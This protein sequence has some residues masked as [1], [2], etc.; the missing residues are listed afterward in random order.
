MRVDGVAV[1]T[2]AWRSVSVRAP[3]DHRVSLAATSPRHRSERISA[4]ADPFGIAIVNSGEFSA[5]TGVRKRPPSGPGLSCCSRIAIVYNT[6]MA[7]RAVSLTL[8]EGNLLWLRG[9]GYGKANLSA[10]VDN[11]VTEARA[12]KLGNAAD[13]RS[14]AGTID[15]ATDDPLLER[16]DTAVRELFAASLSRPARVREAPT[17]YKAPRTRA[18]RG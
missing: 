16:A 8:D 12:G 6:S 18:R 11:L 7:K 2:G 10:A 17:S 13:V 5:A 3:F 15:I 14:I 1:R 4:P 9:R